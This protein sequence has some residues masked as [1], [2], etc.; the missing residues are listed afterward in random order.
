[1]I[2]QD[3]IGPIGFLALGALKEKVMPTKEMPLKHYADSK[4]LTRLLTELVGLAT[5]VLF[6]LLKSPESSQ[7]GQ[8]QP[9]CLLPLRIAFCLMARSQGTNH[10]I[11]RGYIVLQYLV[12]I[13]GFPD[14]FVLCFL[15]E[16]ILSLNAEVD[17][18][19][20]L[21]QKFFWLS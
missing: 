11:A 13:A 8:V 9:K 12:N 14:L 15:T 10:P 18:S 6:Y 4:G 20:I 21:W 1:M 2:I 7:E 5:N 3:G 16:Y 17:G 19:I